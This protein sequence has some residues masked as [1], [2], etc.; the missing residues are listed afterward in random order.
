MAARDARPA[1]EDDEIRDGRLRRKARDFMVFAQEPVTEWART[2]RDILRTAGGD[3][4]VTLGQDEGGTFTRPSQQI[5]AE[6]VDYTGVHP[7][8]HNDDIL[9]TGVLTKVPEKPNLFQETGMMRLEDAERSG[10]VRAAQEL[11]RA[12]RIATSSDAG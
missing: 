12:R 2:L 11:R 3:V 4:L 5:H 9:A 6:A 8:W 10:N 7:W 1:A